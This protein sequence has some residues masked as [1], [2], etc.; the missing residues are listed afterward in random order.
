MSSA[1]T[2]VANGPR[3]S[4][5]SQER[6]RRTRQ[7][8]VDAAIALWTERGWS[9]GF[10]TTTVEEIARAAGVTKGTFYFHFAHKEDVLLEMGWATGEALVEQGNRA[11][12]AG[13]SLDDTLDLML[14][15]MARRT[16]R[17][18]RAAIARTL[19]EFYKHPVRS[20]EH[21]SPRR[22][23]RAVLDQGQARGDLPADIDTADLTDMINAVVMAAVEGWVSGA[24]RTL[25]PVL[26]HRIRVLLAGVR[27]VGSTAGAGRGG[28]RQ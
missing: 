11:I 17:M 14:T 2:P 5:L 6:S 28:R 15:S 13:T 3:R 20:S 1:V 26:R 8:L 9:E 10:D 7:E 16:E 23:W 25:A 12:D 22:A 4:S 19:D 27:V 18:P 21:D 24:H